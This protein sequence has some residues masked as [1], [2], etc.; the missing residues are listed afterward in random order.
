MKANCTRFFKGELASL[1]Y[2]KS[3]SPGEAE[4]LYLPNSFFFLC[5][6]TVESFLKSC[7]C[8]LC[9]GKNLSLPAAIA[10]PHSSETFLPEG[11]IFSEVVRVVGYSEDW[12][13]PV[14][15]AALFCVLFQ[16]VF[17][18]CSENGGCQYLKH[19][20]EMGHAFSCPPFSS[21]VNDISRKA[22]S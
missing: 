8:K 15:M 11:I 9:L 22:A 16:Y 20:R 6:R 10:L 4:D 21:R 3:Y 18:L 5:R 14:E 1:T 2:G 7:N 12:D 19:S 13:V 17:L